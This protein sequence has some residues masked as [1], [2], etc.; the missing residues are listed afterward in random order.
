MIP[1]A[2]QPHGQST[3][4]KKNNTVEIASGIS[5][6]KNRVSG[7]KSKYQSNRLIMATLSSNTTDGGLT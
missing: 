5:A 7:G 2:T 1:P 6:I 3:R 4:A